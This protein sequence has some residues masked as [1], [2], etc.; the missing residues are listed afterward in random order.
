MRRTISF[1]E[2]E[3]RF[4]YR[5]V[6]FAL[7]DGYVLLH[8]APTDDFW[9]LPGGSG[10]LL[11]PSIATL[12]REMREELGVEIQ[13]ERLV[14]VVE[15]FYEDDRFGLHE[16]ALY[17]LMSFP[18]DCPLYRSRGPFDGDEDG[19]RVIFQWFPVDELERVRLFPTFLRTALH[20]IPDSIQHVIHTDTEE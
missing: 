17:Y 12:K 8:R 3:T 2:G 10:E 6:G 13:I 16:I 11:E 19:F 5:V 18:P 15:N 1:N 9:A 14:W 7:H 4:K 20:A